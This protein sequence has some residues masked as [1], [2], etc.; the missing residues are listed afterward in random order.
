MSAQ[1]GAGRVALSEESDGVVRS[2]LSS[3]EAMVEEMSGFP[4]TTVS[5]LLR[6]FRKLHVTPKILCRQKLQGYGSSLLCI[7]IRDSV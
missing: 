7:S 1:V 4:I 5:V 6:N 2:V 3:H